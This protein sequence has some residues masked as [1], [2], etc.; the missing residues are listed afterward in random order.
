MTE[1]GGCLDEIRDMGIQDFKAGFQ[2][3]VLDDDTENMVGAILCPWPSL[4]CCEGH[5]GCA[6]QCVT[7]LASSSQRT[8]KEMV[9]PSSITWNDNLQ[10]GKNILGH[11]DRGIHFCWPRD[12]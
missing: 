12:R 8:T 10:G 4:K 11:G 5:G 3:V 7:M 1:K 9:H 6:V 2:V